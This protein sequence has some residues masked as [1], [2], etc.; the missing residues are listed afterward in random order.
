MGYCKINTTQL[1][2]SLREQQKKAASG[3]EEGS[4]IHSSADLK[5]ALQELNPWLYKLLLPESSQK[6]KSPRGSI[7]EESGH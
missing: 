5:R 3:S 4:L 1:L 2:A 6:E 7:S